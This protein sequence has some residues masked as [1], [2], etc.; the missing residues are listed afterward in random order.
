[1]GQTKAKKGFDALAFKEAAQ[2]RIAAETRGMTHE[3][4][5]AYYHRQAEAGPF[6]EWYKAA[7]REAERRAAERDTKL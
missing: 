2:A 1:M 4:E 7:R 6:S 5:I 3:E